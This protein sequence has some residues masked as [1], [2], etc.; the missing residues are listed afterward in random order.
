MDVPNKWEEDGKI[1]PAVYAQ[2]ANDGL[3]VAVA[4]GTRVPAE[5]AKKDG[6]VFGGVKVEEW[7]GFVSQ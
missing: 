4:F 1:D 7:D 2:L 5:W 3:L 6:T